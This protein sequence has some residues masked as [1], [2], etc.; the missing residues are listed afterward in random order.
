MGQMRQMRQFSHLSLKE[1]VPRQEQENPTASRSGD[2][3]NEKVRRT[4]YDGNKADLL[5]ERLRAIADRAR[6]SGPSSSERTSYGDT[7]TG[8]R[9]S[10]SEA[11]AALR[12][13]SLSAPNLSGID[14]VPMGELGS[15]RIAGDHR[16]NLISESSDFKSK[17]NIS[18]SFDYENML[19]CCKNGRGGGAR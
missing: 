17:L 3:G 16:H 5:K 14:S 13:G 8:K 9:S 11:I 2:D 6:G 10:T 1:T 4:D 18:K 19:C 7:N 15:F 12:R